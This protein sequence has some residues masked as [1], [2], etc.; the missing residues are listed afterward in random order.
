MGCYRGEDIAAVEGVAGARA[1]EFGAGDLM[2]LGL[3]S[4][5]NEAEESV[6]GS[7]P[8]LVV[9][10]QGQGTTLGSDAG[11]DD[12]QV[13]GTR[14]EFAG[15]MAQNEGGGEYILRGDLMRDI[16]QVDVWCNA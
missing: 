6:V 10:L 13:Y 12:G 7:D 3:G 1:A 14:W 8:Q 9:A 11:V 4:V 5:E 16:D 15:G 2:G